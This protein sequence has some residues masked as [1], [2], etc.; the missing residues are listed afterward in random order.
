MATKKFTRG[1]PAGGIITGAIRGI[2]EEKS[3]I[4]KNEAAQER[5]IRIEKKKWRVVSVYNIQKM[6]TIRQILDERMRIM[7][8]N[9]Y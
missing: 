3:E 5:I 6:A 1:R 8:E 9:T 4:E 2:Q 7:K